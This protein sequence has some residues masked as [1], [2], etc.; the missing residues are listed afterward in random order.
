M[1]LENFCKMIHSYKIEIIENSTKTN[2]LYNFKFII[3]P[4]S[5]ED[6]IIIDKILEEYGKR[7]VICNKIN[8][9][10]KTVYIEI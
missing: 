6:K 3:E 5:K 4:F 8:E 9:K 2:G 1:T 10:K 7:I